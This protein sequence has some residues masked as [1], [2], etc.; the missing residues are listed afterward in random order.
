M[1]QRDKKKV[2]VVHG[3][4]EKLRKE[5]FAFLRSI[6]LDPVEWTSAI[7]ATG[8][9]S[10]YI[11]EVLATAF[12]MAQ[13]VV[14]LLTP[15][16][17]VYLHDSLAGEDDADEVRPQ[18]QARPNV[19]FEAG[20][21]MGRDE[22]RTVLVEM[23]KQKMFSDIGG[24]HTLRMDNS[25]E[26]REEL[27][28][29]LGTAGCDVDISGTDW[30]STGDLTPP[31]EL[32]SGLPLGKR[33]LSN[34]ALQGPRLRARFARTSESFSTMYVRNLGPGWVKNLNV[35]VLEQRIADLCRPAIDL[36]VE[37]MPQG[38]EAPTLRFAHHH[39]SPSTSRFEVKLTATSET[40]ESIE[41]TVFI[42][43]ESN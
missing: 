29:R 22:E 3:R 17:V 5:L 34:A 37:R 12:D 25:L 4:N 9:P 10:P 15:D 36:P 43:S 32:D 19:L 39:G 26:M 14:V 11:G 38:D 24:R 42:G 28:Q 40:G 31:T 21:A 18:G 35:E 33:V 2:F 1:T 8:K 6:G 13:A 7:K 30:H 27:A 16:D 41:E 20:M 23:G